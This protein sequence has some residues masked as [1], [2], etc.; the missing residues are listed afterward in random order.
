MTD[1]L[2]DHHFD[3]LMDALRAPA[4]ASEIADAGPM[5]AAMATLVRAG[6]VTAELDLPARRARRVGPKAAVVLIAALAT[7]GAG[8]AAAATNHLPSG[9]QDAISGAVA[10]VGLDLPDSSTDPDAGPGA[11]APTGEPEA[12]APDA[13]GPDP[14]G[15]AHHGL[16]TAAGARDSNPGGSENAG[17][18]AGDNL[19]AAASAAGQTVAE[20]CQDTT[21]EPAA[22]DSSDSSH[23]KSDSH[24]QP[25][26]PATDSGNANPH[27]DDTPADDDHSNGAHSGTTSSDQGKAKS[28]DKVKDKNSSAP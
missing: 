27:S 12:D 24:D 23:G 3:D 6:D 15:P 20:Y 25:D 11:P 9:V 16:C 1:L 21:K 18:T 8:A 4:A 28:I 14:A 10:H 22:T 17:G 2:L 5:A 19:E 13:R 26:A 7:T